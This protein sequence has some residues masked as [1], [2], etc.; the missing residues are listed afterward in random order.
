MPLMQIPQPGAY[1]PH[2]ADLT[3]HTPAFDTLRTTAAD[4]QAA[5]TAGKLTSVQIVEE[6]HRSI[7]KHNAYL[8]AIYELAP[9]AVS[10]AREMDD[11]R[12]RGQV[13]GP[14]HGI[15]VVLK[16]NTDTEMAM[17]MHTTAGAVAFLDNEPARNAAIVDKLLNAGMIVLGK[18]SMSEMSFWKGSDIPCGW[19]A[20]NGQA[21]SAYVY[22]GVDKDDSVAG[23]SSPL[24]SSTGSAI[25]CSA[26]LTPIAIGTETFGSIVQP[27]TRAALYS[28]KP[29]LGIVPGRGIVPVSDEYDTAG[30][31][32]KTPK[33]VADLL[34]VLVDPSKTNVP[35]GGYAAALGATWKDIKVGT[36]DPNIWTP[37]PAFV[38][39]VEEV[40]EEIIDKTNVACR[41]TAG[42]AKWSY[43]HVSP[44][45]NSQFTMPDGRSAI[46]AKLTF[47]FEECLNRYLADLKSSKIRTLAELVEYNKIRADTALP[48]ENPSQSTL[49]ASLHDPHDS[50][51]LQE[52]ETHLQ[53]VAAKFMSIWDQYDIDI[54]LAPGDSGVYNFSAAC[55]FPMA[56]LP[57]STLDEYNGRPYGLVACAKPHGEEILMKTMDAWEESNPFGPRREPK[58]FL[59]R[60]GM[61]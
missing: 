8:K 52:I 18:A 7:V 41:V 36:L 23:H 22:G 49:E 15:P 25:A 5:L 6:Y 58:A 26:G 30:P 46:M 45:T 1:W 4:L 11:L 37:D 17:G 19:S 54:I 38:K 34:T 47:T 12:S 9:G 48:P 10:R 16:D 61:K 42:S 3:S 44:L 14:L 39:Y 51:K 24:G 2:F 57:V 21:Q 13:L 53:S 43:D 27:A 31:F 35:L 28:I 32:G 33:D 50:A 20:A 60:R 56:T 55:G 59:E 29:T 40:A